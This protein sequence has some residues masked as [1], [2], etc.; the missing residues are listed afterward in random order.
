MLTYLT[1]KCFLIIKSQ[2]LQNE[3]VLDFLY[4]SIIKRFNRDSNE[5]RAGY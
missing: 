4:M 3:S 5:A 2:R 1:V